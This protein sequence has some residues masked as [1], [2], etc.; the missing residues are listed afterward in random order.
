MSDS[1][2]AALRDVVSS[3]AVLADAGDSTP[4]VAPETDVEWSGVLQL[5]LARG[6]T[7]RVEGNGTRA[8]WAPDARPAELVLSTARTR[9]VV[10]YEP[11]DGTLTA[12]A[13]T[14]MAELAEVGAGGG[15][16]VTPDV[17]H[18]TRSTLGGVLAS[19][20]SGFDRL[21]YGP[22]RHNLLG[23]RVVLADGSVASAGGRLVKNVTGYD[24]HR[25]WAGSFG[26]LCVVLEASLR[27]YPLPDAR[28]CAR[29]AYPTRADA[30]A[31]ARRVGNEPIRPTAL[32]VHGGELFVFLVGRTEVVEWELERVRDTADGEAVERLDA[33]AERDAR[34]RLRDFLPSGAPSL[35]LATRP[36]RFAAALDGVER[37]AHA[38]DVPTETVAHPAIAT[39]TVRLGP[40]TEDAYTRFRDSLSN[41]DER[42]TWRD[43][44][45]APSA[46]L[47]GATS[48]AAALMRELEAALDPTGVLGAGGARV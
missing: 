28:A 10:A 6:I 20:C 21:R 36:S 22:A 12:R 26:R 3:D 11:G 2:L 38:C 16:H 23:M 39:A 32:V 27:L 37:A 48:D 13:G 1:L 47:E 46:S 44:P 40:A 18:P 14:A 33:G 8:G 31:A 15:H 43:V 35:E 4:R 29:L 34:E 45:G 19:G 41:F 5:A 7:C 30:L 42:V 9:G 25:L 24:L 17:A